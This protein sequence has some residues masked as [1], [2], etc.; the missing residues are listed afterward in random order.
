MEGIEHKTISVNGIN[1]H[2]AEKGKGPVVLFLHGFPELWYSWRHQILYT[3]AH[4]YRAV[5]PDLRGYG[6]TDRSTTQRLHQIH[7]SPSDRRHRCSP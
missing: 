1:M 7:R 4:G 6:D 5:A 3:A 2:I